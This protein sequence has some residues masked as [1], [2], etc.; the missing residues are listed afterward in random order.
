MSKKQRYRIRNWPQ[1]NKSL[2]KRGSLTLWFDEESVKKWHEIKKTGGRGRPPKYTDIAILC[3]LTL[4]VVFRLPLRATQGLA[5]SLIDL[6]KLSI[7]SADYTTLCRRQ[8]HLKV[9]LQKR[10][11]GSESLHAVFDSTGLKVFG[12]GE[13]KVRQHGYSQRRTWRKLH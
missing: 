3:M 8:K 1:Y 11:A 9:P 10:M 6:L 7:E 4:K 2:V 12:E 13:W 5:A